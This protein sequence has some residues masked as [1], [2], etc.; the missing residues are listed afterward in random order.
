MSIR[1]TILNA[2]RPRLTRRGQ[3]N[4]RR[5]LLTLAIE[6]SC[7]DTSVAVLEKRS[8]SDGQTSAVLHFHKKITS[9]NTAYHG[10]HPLASLYSHQENLAG[11]VDE[12]ILHLP[13]KDTSQA[14]RGS[15]DV[16]SKKLPDFI[17]VTRGPGMRSN[18]FTGIDTAKGLAAAW[19]VLAKML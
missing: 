9:N 1:S 3:P 16:L 6:T 12:A 5:F 11:L 10:V 19:Q 13:P 18:L 8:S 4:T 15:N 17:S 7:D 2:S 14:S